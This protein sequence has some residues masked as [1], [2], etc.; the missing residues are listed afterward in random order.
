MCAWAA[1]HF[2][3]RFYNMPVNR[4]CDGARE[5]SLMHCEG[6]KTCTHNKNA[7][8]QAA[9]KK[10]MFQPFLPKRNPFIVFNSSVI[11]L[12]YIISCI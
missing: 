11:C 5:V 4:K 3:P 6:D 10:A 7:M 8:T 12:G 1:V 9:I 2:V